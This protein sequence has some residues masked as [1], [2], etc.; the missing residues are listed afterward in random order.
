M[1]CSLDKPY[2]EKCSSHLQSAGTR[3]WCICRWPLIPGRGSPP[4]S[5]HVPHALSLTE[6]CA[7]LTQQQPV[8]L[9][10]WH[11]RDWAPAGTEGT[12][13]LWEQVAQM[14]STVALAFTDS[15]P[16]TS[17]NVPC[18]QLAE[19]EWTQAWFTDGSAGYAGTN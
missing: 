19:K 17:K 2:Q 16:R 8:T 5:Q 9:W 13:R 6:P 11:G 7:G 4:S 14:P 18:D 3:V 15:A 1:G 12:G 10:R